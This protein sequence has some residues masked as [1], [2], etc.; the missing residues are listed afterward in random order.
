MHRSG[1]ISRSRSPYR[2]YVGAV[3]VAVLFYLVPIAVMAG[4]VHLGWYAHP[5]QQP[6]ASTT[7]SVTEPAPGIAPGEPPVLHRLTV[8]PPGGGNLF[9]GAGKISPGGGKVLA[10]VVKKVLPGDDNG[11]GVIDEDES[12]WDCATMGNQVCGSAVIA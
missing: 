4:C 9:P 12:G 7:M 8:M 11:D 5:E 1:S 2:P 10:G 3:I 6:T